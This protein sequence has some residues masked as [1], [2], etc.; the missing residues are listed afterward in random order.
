MHVFLVTVNYFE[1]LKQ[2][3]LSLLTVEDIR[4]TELGFFI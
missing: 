2:S 1:P 3:N 4:E